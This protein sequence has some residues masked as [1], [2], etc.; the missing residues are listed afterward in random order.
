M[1]VVFGSINV[2]LTFRVDHQPAPGE[3][4]LCPGYLASPGGKGANQ[5]AAAA[6]AG[7]ATAMVGS[8]GPDGFAALAVDTMRASGADVS[9]VATVDSPTAC[10]TITVDRTGENA[11]VVAS[12]ANLA[13]KAEQV[14]DDLLGPDSVLMLQM[15]VDLTE[16]WR[17]LERAQAAGARTMLNVAPAAAVPESALR[18]LDYLIVNEIEGASIATASDIEPQP[19]EDLPRRLHERYGLTCVLTLGA[20]GAV[21]HGPEGGFAIPALNVKPTDTTGAGDTCVGYLAAGLD[22]GLPGVEAAR[23]ASVAAAIACTREGAQ[24]GIPYATD[25]ETALAQLPAAAPRV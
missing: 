21:L 15:E 7:A 16:N 25:V 9:A 24:I 8:V 4:V 20:A 23:R 12:G 6:R 17:L 13:T 18:Q 22:A 19:P 2:D 11:I 14:T 1:I 5:A 3:T 10:A